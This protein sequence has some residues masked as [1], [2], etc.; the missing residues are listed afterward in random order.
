MAHR[1]LYTQ[2]FYTPM[3]LHRENFTHR[4]ICTEKSLHR[5]ALHTDAFTHRS[6]YTQKLLDRE[7]LHT[8]PFTHRC[9]YAQK[10]LHREVF[11]QRAFSIF[12]TSFWRSSTFISCEKVTSEAPESKFYTIFGSATF[13]S[14]EKVASEIANFAILPSVLDIRSSLR[15]GD[16]QHGT[17]GCWEN[18]QLS[19]VVSTPLK[20]MKVNGKDDIPYIMENKSHVPNHQSVIIFCYVAN[21][22]ACWSLVEWH[23]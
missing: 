13:I 9:A 8:G 4:S 15:K 14:C 23:H 12:Y 3:F 22:V 5:G 7:V 21:A 10:L 6:F 16:V 18:L 17:E 20:K 1:C 11:A 19:L 2:K